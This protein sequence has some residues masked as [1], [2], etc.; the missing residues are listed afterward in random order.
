M[1]S[2]YHPDGANGAATYTN[3]SRY[4]ADSSP[5]TASVA[6][7]E[8]SAASTSISPHHN[9]QHLEYLMAGIHDMMSSGDKHPAGSPRH[10]AAGAAGGRPNPMPDTLQGLGLSF[11]AQ[12]YAPGTLNLPGMP[13]PGGTPAHSIDGDVHP[14]PFF[15][16]AMGTSEGD[17]LEPSGGNAAP[18]SAPFG[19]PNAAYGVP[20][21]PFGSSSAA[22][23]ASGP[24][25]L[26]AEMNAEINQLGAKLLQ[27]EH[28][29]TGEDGG[30]NASIG[31]DWSTLPSF[32]FTAANGETLCTL[33]VGQ[34]K[35]A[36]S[37]TV[38]ARG[39]DAKTAKGAASHKMM[40][41]ICVEYGAIHMAKVKAKKHGSRDQRDSAE[42]MAKTADATCAEDFVHRLLRIKSPRPL[43]EVAGFPGLN[44]KFP[45][46]KTGYKKASE[47]FAAPERKG[48]F[49]LRWVESM[50]NFEVD[51]AR[52]CLDR[53]K[54]PAE[55]PL[56]DAE[57][58]EKAGKLE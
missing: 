14:L 38:A 50:N 55:R 4:S 33:V 58:V 20:N 13:V 18:A 8:V 46:W 7:T 5:D 37:V 30:A 56:S 9:E 54:A 47:W 23:G 10:V 48:K 51:L 11:N 1:G 44:T 34:A 29:K 42:D 15:H 22:Y 27:A 31:I 53:T 3:R 41:Q 28:S 32:F 49:K 12:Y 39:P 25:R 57:T 21:A 52:D 45:G 24:A 2:Y 36:T 26:G 17:C 19:A 43:S 16:G 6:D 40:I 35:P